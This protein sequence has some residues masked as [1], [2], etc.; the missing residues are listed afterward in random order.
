M[1]APAHPYSALTPDLVIGAILRDGLHHGTMTKMGPLG[2]LR[3]EDRARSFSPA[4]DIASPE[5]HQQRRPAVS[6]FAP[7]S[8]Q[9]GLLARAQEIDN[10]ERELRAQQLIAHPDFEQGG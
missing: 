10:L 2:D 4:F 8:E 9:S 3:F 7:D 1:N 6:F 5:V